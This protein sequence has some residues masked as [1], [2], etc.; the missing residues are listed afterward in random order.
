MASTLG[1]WWL[2]NKFWHMWMSWQAEAGQESACMMQEW[3]MHVRQGSKTRVCMAGQ[4]ELAMCMHIGK[5]RMRAKWWSECPYFH[6]PIATFSSTIESYPLSFVTCVTRSMYFVT[7]WGLD[8]NWLN[9]ARI[10]WP[11]GSCVAFHMKA[12]IGM[13]IAS[14]LEEHACLARLYRMYNNTGIWLKV[15]SAVRL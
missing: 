14:T 8:L 7:Q 2:P 3:H 11:D 5:T 12:S 1:I 13:L 4:W 6:Q 10:A 15:R 9:R